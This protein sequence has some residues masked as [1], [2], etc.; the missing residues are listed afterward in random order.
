MT[1]TTSNPHLNGNGSS[2][3]GRSR[4]NLTHD[5]EGNT[6]ADASLSSMCTS[7]KNSTNHLGEGTNDDSNLKRSKPSRFLWDLRHTLVHR[8][9]KLNRQHQAILLLGT[10]MT[11]VSM[12]R[13]FSI[14]MSHRKWINAPITYMQRQCPRPNYPIIQKQQQICITTLTDSENKALRQKLFGWRNYNGILELTWNNKQKYA[15]KH[16]YRLE[17]GSHLLDRSRPP[18]WT[19]ILAVQS[20]LDSK[21]KEGTDHCDWVMWLDVSP[22]VPTIGYIGKSSQDRYAFY[23]IRY[24]LYRYESM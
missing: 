22:T 16:G 19:K 13:I 21:S 3:A 8:G 9:S 6:D 1:S 12:H 5:V 18:A 17:N 2:T 15:Q 4:S 23:V 14:Y 20:L 11:I 24:T 10:L 7:S